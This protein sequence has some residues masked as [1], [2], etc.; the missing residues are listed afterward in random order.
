MVANHGARRVR[1]CILGVIPGDV[2]ELAV[3][4]CK[5]TLTSKVKITPEKIKSLVE[6]FAEYSVTQTQ[7]EKRIQRRVDAMKPGHMVSLG[8]IYNSLE[9]GMSNPVDWFEPEGVGMKKKTEMAVEQSTAG[10]GDPEKTQG[11][12]SQH[13]P[14][15]HPES[16]SSPGTD[17]VENSQ[18]GDAPQTQTEIGQS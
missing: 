11:S 14:K 16:E 2:T 5:K 7:I 3:E 10:K 1:A 17:K 15:L 13:N 8:K 6:K 12:R 18:P 4:A 9:D